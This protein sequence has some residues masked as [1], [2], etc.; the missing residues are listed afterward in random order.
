[1]DD[2]AIKIFDN[3]NKNI[4]FADNGDYFRSELISLFEIVSIF[5]NEYREI[6]I[7]IINNILFKNMT[8]L[9]NIVISQI[10][11]LIIHVINLI[12]NRYNSNYI[13]EIQT[14]YCSYV[15][16]CLVLADIADHIKTNFDEHLV[17]ISETSSNVF[18]FHNKTFKIYYKIK[19]MSTSYSNDLCKIFN[20]KTLYIHHLN[21]DLKGALKLFLEN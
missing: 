20:D 8:Y 1:M 4:K 3:I 2:V 7:K 11:R 21:N 14:F 18:I 15:C 9:N 19:L 13:G 16:E 12:Y 6:L 17:P 10:F 5:G